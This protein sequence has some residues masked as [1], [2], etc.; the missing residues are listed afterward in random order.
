MKALIIGAG[1][2]A[3]HHIK[4]LMKL[5]VEIYGVY[6]IRE[7]NAKKLA[8]TYLTHVVTDL[9]T[10][11]QEADIVYLLTP[12]STRLDYVRKIAVYNKPLF[13]EKPVAVSISDA[14]AMEMILEENNMIAMVGFT[15]RFR[16]GY[17]KLQTLLEA[18]T[19]GE[20]VQ[21]FVVRMGPGPGYTG[22][23]EDSWRTDRKYVCGMAIESLSHDIDFMQSLAGEIT[24]VEGQVK[25]TVSSLPQFDNNADAVLCFK[26]GAIGTITCSWSSAVAYNVKGIIGTKG[27]AILSGE[28]I[29]DNTVFTWETKDG[30]EEKESLDDIFQ[31]GEGYLEESRYF[32]SCILKGQKPVCDMTTGRK[33]LE[34]SHAILDTSQKRG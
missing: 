2:I 19:L 3:H 32:L 7:E 28:D 9:D 31:A 27:T 26:D 33:A 18:G 34:V 29:W 4:S 23:L 10:A 21:A 11:L 25:G 6:D 16:K 20:I 12:P 1:G 17:Q 15:Q 14:L 5:N 24:I 13:M 30:K 22:T 8:E